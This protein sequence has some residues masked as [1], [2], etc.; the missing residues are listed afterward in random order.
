MHRILQR[1]EQVTMTPRKDRMKLHIR[2]EVTVMDLGEMDIWDGANL[3]LLRETL[4]NLIEVEDCRRIGVELQYVKYIPSGF[5]GMLFDCYEKGVEIFLY[6]PLPHVANMLWF[7]QFFNH[8]SG[9][10]FVLH[11][12][13]REEF[14]PVVHENWKNQTP[15]NEPTDSKNGQKNSNSVS[16]ISREN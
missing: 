15:W 13:P 14:V 12:V 1:E 5:F 4:T 10:C 7:R 11:E 9:S 8:V 6:S 2:D 3:A 16:A